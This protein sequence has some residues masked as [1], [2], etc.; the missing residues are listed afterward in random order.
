MV[1][2]KA[3][4]SV[5]GWLSQGARPVDSTPASVVETPADRP[6]NTETTIV[7]PSSAAKPGPSTAAE[8]TVS[9]I[10]LGGNQTQVTGVEGEAHSWFWRLLEQAGYERWWPVKLVHTSWVTGTIGYWHPTGGEGLVHTLP[11][12]TWLMKVDWLDKAW[13]WM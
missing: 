3:D 12:Q 10:P 1:K 7:E 11:L 13:A 8:L 5:Y 2:R 6:C 4:V 9:P